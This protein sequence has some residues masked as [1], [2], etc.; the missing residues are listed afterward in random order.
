MV[1]LH[2]LIRAEQHRQQTLAFSH[3]PIR[4][5]FGGGVSPIVADAERRAAAALGRGPW[6]DED[7]ALS[8]TGGVV[9]A[10]VAEA[11]RRAAAA[12][13]GNGF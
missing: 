1:T 11:M 5:R 12:N 2:D 8:R 10:I 6:R 9:P 13:R 7:L 3:G 4:V